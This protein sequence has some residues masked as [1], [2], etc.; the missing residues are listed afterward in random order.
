MEV[1]PTGAQF[2]HSDP[3]DSRYAARF[4]GREI[5]RQ[6]VEAGAQYVVMWARDGDFAYYNS[7][8]LSK[9]P[10][11]GDRDPL[12]EAVDEAH[13][14]GIP[15]IAYCVVQQGGLYLDQHPEFAMRD[16]RGQKID[17]FCFNSGYLDA[18]RQILSEQLACGIDGF[19]V[20]MLDQGF[21]PPCGCWCD[22]CRTLFKTEAGVDPPPGP[23]W[24]QAWDRF[25]DFRYGSSQ[26]FA[27]ALR[28]H[29]KAT[30]SRASIDFNYHGNPPFSWEV[31]QRPV[32]HAGNGDF[33]TG[34]TG[35]WGFSALGVGLNAEFYRAA[36]PNHPFQVAMQRGVRM[37]HDQTTRPVPDM[38]W[39]L[40]T[41]LA[42]GAFVTMVDKT[43]FDGSLDPIAYERIK[44]TFRPTFDPG[45]LD[46]KEELGF[47]P[48]ADVGLYYSA[49]SRDWFGRDTPEAYFQGFQGAHKALVLE[50]VPYRVLLDENADAATLERF[51]IVLLPNVQ[52]LGEAE[53]A[54]LDAYVRQGG[55]LII[56][57]WSG[58]F[59]PRGEPLDRTVL[60]DLIGA[61][62]LR[63]LP[64]RDNWVDFSN[65]DRGGFIREHEVLLPRAD[66]PILV[67]GAATTYE[68]TTAKAFGR[69]RAPARTTRQND[70]KE[71]TDWPMSAGDPM[72]PALLLNRVGNGTVLTFAASPDQ[73]T[74]SEHPTLEARKLL[75]ASIRYARPEPRLVLDFPAN[76]EAVVTDDKE[77][78]LLRVFLIGYNS[79]PQSTPPKNRPYVIPG[80]IENPATF[81]GSLTFRAAGEV[82]GVGPGVT[83]KSVDDTH[84]I[85]VLFG[86]G[87]VKIPY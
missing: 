40:Q 11:L 42:H 20:D 53:V 13:A 28:D 81:Y 1:G 55:S 46:L 85:M 83:V 67:E 2:G 78:R 21:G 66:L 56:T 84:A 19:H 35:I 49:R 27:R 57:G 51:P 75:A 9:P 76:V 30:N 70:G 8:L 12:R 29:V 61:R 74:A 4:D 63:R 52:I 50:H 5:V 24:D 3:T 39:E 41:L 45:P 15:L 65:H 14:R 64:T 48:V 25:L 22:T 54:R 17:R 34:E 77:H 26:R 36:F 73:A 58:Q 87:I 47:E 68:P 32:Q 44:D 60:Q 6:C 33:V 80:P 43:A 62:V 23:T 37:Y 69:L 18:M 7:A 16:P 71:G 72:G 82:Q 31:G 59:G 10:G 86:F 38:Q 79:A